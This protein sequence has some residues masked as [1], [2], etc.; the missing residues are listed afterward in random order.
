MNDYEELDAIEKAGREAFEQG[1]AATECPY[2]FSK[3]PFWD[4]KDYRGFELQY[5]PKMNAWMNGWIDAKT[6]A[7]ERTK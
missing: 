2:S 5:R 7:N 6:K 1:I 4:R 3:S